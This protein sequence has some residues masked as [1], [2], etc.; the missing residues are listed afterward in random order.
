MGRRDV[1][2]D[3]VMAGTGFEY[4]IAEVVFGDPLF[5]IS[6]YDERNVRR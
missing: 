6:Q 5:F 2:A 4:Q 1:L 3:H